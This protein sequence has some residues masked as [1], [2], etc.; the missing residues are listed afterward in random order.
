MTAIMYTVQNQVIVIKYDKT[1]RNRTGDSKSNEDGKKDNADGRR[2]HELCRRIG[3][4][5]DCQQ[6]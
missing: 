3:E 6:P 4:S 5:G 2:H 1:T